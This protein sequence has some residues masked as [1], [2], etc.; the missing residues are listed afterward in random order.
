MLSVWH[1]WVIVAIVLF[2][3]EIF[4][5]GFLLASFGIGCLFSALAAGLGY[6]LK[7][8]ILGFVIGTLIAF[9]G[10]RPFFTRY[11]Y[12]GDRG[13]RTNVDALAGKV[14]RVLEQVDPQSGSG[15]VMVGGDDWKAVSANGS[16]IESGKTVEVVRVEGNTV[17]VKQLET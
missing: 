8:Q 10:V 3:V 14:G 7:T 1:L 4:T 17:F 11:C 6:T 5:P 15:R 16:V 2:M 9:F 13:V 12:K